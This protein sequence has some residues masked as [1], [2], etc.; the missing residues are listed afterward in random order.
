MPLFEKRPVLKNLSLIFLAFAAFVLQSCSTELDVN[1][2]YRET[3]VFY[4]ILDPTQPFQT[5]RIG[6]GFLSDGRSAK[7]IA[8]DSPDS[9]LFNPAILEVILFEIKL[10]NNGRFDTIQKVS[11]FPDTI[12][13]KVITGDFYA[14]DQLVFRTP[15]MQLDTVTPASLIH[16]FVRIRNKNSGNVTEAS[17]RIPGRELTIR[18]WAAIGPDVDGPFSL[19]FGTRKRTVI[20]VNKSPNTAVIQLSLNWKIQVITE[21]DTIEEIWKMSS[22]MENDIPG[23]L[24]D[25]VFGPGSLW[26]FI[27]GELTKR[28]N[29]KVIGRKILPSE[30]EIYAANKDY[31]NYR[32]VNGNY[33]AITQSQPVYS[34][35][36]NGALGIFCGRNR[37][38]FSVGLDR[39]V[40][41]TLD[42]R[43]PDF[44]LIK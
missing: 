34:N 17:T 5:F 36:S 27:Q 9:S 43:F 4:G 42:V 3:K 15:L 12:N 18:N 28:G 21:A 20:S 16:Y 31:D 30:M 39:S 10:Q 2:P 14:P 1:A 44:K 41:D 26:N 24:K 19:D 33:N 25:I 22:G 32:V 8:K 6:K 11:L 29:E 23:D 37:R 13:N 35:L 7:E 40:V 38:V